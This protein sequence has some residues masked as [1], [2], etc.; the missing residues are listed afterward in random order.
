LRALRD[1][2]VFVVAAVIVVGPLVLVARRAHAAGPFFYLPPAPPAASATP[3]PVDTEVE[4]HATLGQRLLSRRRG[5]EAIAEFR[6][7]YELRADARFLFDIA[8][9]YRQLGLNDQAI[10][11]YE[12]YLSAA[13]DAPDREDVEEQLAALRRRGGAPAGVPVAPRPTFAHDVVI[14]PVAGPAVASAVA[15]ASPAPAETPRRPLWRRWWVW[16]AV[17]AVVVGGTVA[18]F[19]LRGAHDDVPSTAL[20]DQKFY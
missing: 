4:R 14:V 2:R 20:G 1:I 11:F 16:A 3:R 5:Q 7:A 17:G 12:R 9:G 18:A 8:E 13:P 10:F 15:P 19:A 6:R